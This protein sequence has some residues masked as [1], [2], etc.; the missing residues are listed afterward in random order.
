VCAP[1]VQA[2]DGSGDALALGVVVA[3][4]CGPK[5]WNDQVKVKVL[6]ALHA[7]SE[8]ENGQLRGFRVKL[9]IKLPLGEG[10]QEH[11]LR[12][13]LA[14]R[15]ALF[16]VQ[17]GDMEADFCVDE[18][19]EIKVVEVKLPTVHALDDNTNT[20]MLVQLDEDMLVGDA[21][22]AWERDRLEAR[23]TKTPLRPREYDDVIGLH[24]AAER[25]W[26]TDWEQWHELKRLEW[27]RRAQGNRTVL[28][29]LSDGSVTGDG[30]AAHSTYGWLCYGAEADGRRVEELE[31]VEVT[32]C[33]MAG[34]GVV[35]GPPEWTSSTRAE[36]AG[37]LA[38]LIGALEAGW[39][40][41]IDL[42]LDNDSAVA[43]GGGLVLGSAVGAPWDAV[44]LRNGHCIENADIWTEFV[45]WR[46][47]HTR[48]GATVT[49]RWHPGHPERRAKR[50]DWSLE[51]R[52]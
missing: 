46:D 47:K 26:S 31:D 27:T 2:T 7:S 32:E 49:V 4:D 22:A 20:S 10:G 44:A 42:R 33:V 50:E 1:L 30:F 18:L 37:A 39:R 29:L 25:G 17:D 36:A 41:D 3:D 14:A 13:C 6:R 28:R 38:A 12:G 40:G 48:T 9:P 23:G 52:H 43:R 35:A 51:D 21:V 11:G 8:D 16:A 45:A 34:C 24:A 19:L 15:G 5:G